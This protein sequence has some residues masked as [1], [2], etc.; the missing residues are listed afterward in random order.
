MSELLADEYYYAELGVA[1]IYGVRAFRL[2]SDGTLCSLH[3]ESFKWDAQ[4][5]TYAGECYR[6]HFAPHPFCLCGLHAYAERLKA[7]HWCHGE[8]VSLAMYGER[9]DWPEDVVEDDYIRAVG[10][11]AGS[12]NIEK[13][14]TA[15]KA[16]RAR[17][18]GLFDTKDSGPLADVFNGFCRA[19]GIPVLP[20]GYLEDDDERIRYAQEHQLLTSGGE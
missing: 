13:H 3:Q 11:V 4:G 2:N 8:H 12:G 16:E 9:P 14:K 10:I 5:Y 6:G 18:L 19:H 1:G 7:D 20:P 17:I 15:W